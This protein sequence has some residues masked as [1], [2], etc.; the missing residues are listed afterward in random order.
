MYYLYRVTNKVNGKYYIGVHKTDNF[1]DSYHGSGVVIKKALDKYG[2]ETFSKTKL[3]ETED[4]DEAYLAENTAV[5]DLWK[6]DPTCYNATAGGRG[7]FSHIDSSGDNNCMKKPEVVKR[8]VATKRASGHYESE[9]HK[10]AQAAATKAATLARTG[11]KDSQETKDKR[12]AAVKAAHQRPEV[13]AKHALAMKAKRQKFRLIDPS[14]AEHTV[15]NLTEWCTENQMPMSTVTVKDHG[16]AV[17]RGVM[18]GW[19]IW[20]ISQ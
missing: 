12:N 8:V 7:G 13:K 19:R 10:R 20:K 15:D 18:K 16:E 9:A 6:T 17:K 4:E 3:F 5:G 14:G 1:D 2:I 11:S